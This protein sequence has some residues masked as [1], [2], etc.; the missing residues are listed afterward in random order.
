MLYSA[1]RFFL[2]GGGFSSGLNR[3][4]AVGCC[5][6]KWVFDPALNRRDVA[7]CCPYKRAFDPIL[8]FFSRTGG[9]PGKKDV[10]SFGLYRKCRTL[11][12]TSCGTGEKR[13]RLFRVVLAGAGRC[14]PGSASVRMRF[15]PG[16]PATPVSS[17]RNPFPGRGKGA[18]EK[19]PVRCGR[20]RPCAHRPSRRNTARWPAGRTV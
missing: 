5:P 14:H 19:R 8:F 20:P 16:S 6:Y 10:E 3:R 11:R 9:K 18:P 17:G 12:A 2:K 13:P 4:D 7:G 1:A 15:I